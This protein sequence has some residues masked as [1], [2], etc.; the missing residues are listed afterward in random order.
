MTFSAEN[1]ALGR[2][3]WQVDIISDGNSKLAVD[4]FPYDNYAD[5]SCSMSGIIRNAWW[6]V[7]LGQKRTIG[8]VEV[9][10]RNTL[11]KIIDP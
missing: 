8:R 2:P 11:G 3:T 1:F 4:G 9:K 6:A 7:D 10:N 5:G